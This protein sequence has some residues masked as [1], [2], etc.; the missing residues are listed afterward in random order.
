MEETQIQ[1]SC[2][3]L[4]STKTQ[5]SSGFQHCQRALWHFFW[6]E[7]I[8]KPIKKVWKNSAIWECW[9]PLA[10]ILKFKI[11]LLAKFVHPAYDIKFADSCEQLESLCVKSRTQRNLKHKVSSVRA[12]IKCS[13]VCVL[14]GMFLFTHPTQAFSTLQVTPLCTDI[15]AKTWFYLKITNFFRWLRSSSYSQLALNDY[16]TI[17]EN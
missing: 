12:L 5:S 1:D 3:W 4:S 17:D 8:G 10:P 15:V 14:Q 7:N 16:N 9:K 11:Q 6:I 13:C 2:S